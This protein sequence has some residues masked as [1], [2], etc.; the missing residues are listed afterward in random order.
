PTCRQPIRRQPA[1]QD[2][3][4]VEHLTVPQQVHDRACFPGQGRSADAAACAAFGRAASMISN[5]A[6]SIAALTNQASNAIGGGYTP[7]SNSAWKNGLN[8][9]VS[10]AAAAA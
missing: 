10:D 2:T 7:P 3:L 8:R 5:A 1:V 4:R 6:S 9:H